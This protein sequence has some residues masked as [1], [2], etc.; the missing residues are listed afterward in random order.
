VEVEGFDP[1]TVTADRWQ[2]PGL[3]LRVDT[4]AE[5]QEVTLFGAAHLVSYRLPTT[6][7]CRFTLSL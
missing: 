3:D 7:T 2:L 4:P 1:G 5:L 6:E